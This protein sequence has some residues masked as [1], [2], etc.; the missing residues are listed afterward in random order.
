MKAELKR[1]VRKLPQPAQEISRRAYRRSQRIYRS[2]ATPYARTRISL[3]VKPL[4]FAWG[5]DRGQ[6]IARYYV[7]E[8]FLREFAKD[9]HGHCLELSSDRYTSRFG[10]KARIAKIDILNLEHGNPNTT[11]RADL[12]K[13]N[14]IPDN[15]FD[16]IIFTHALH[17]IYEFDK[18]IADLYRIL[19]PGGVL[20]V[21]VPHVSMCDPDERELWRFTQEGL[22]V[23][24]AHSFDDENI[25]MRAYGNSLT[26][27]GQ[28]RGL[29]AHEFT[30]RELHR[31]DLRFAVDI[32]ARAMKTY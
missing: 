11:I 9:I 4:S 13:P 1:V 22:R 27:A 29:A 28:I 3:G 20:L 19:R 17:V 6:E 16:C 26:A 14:D 5:G 25:T 18:A 2:P 31:H 32:C 30:K 15:T 23:A 7:E 21:A 12:T 10:E 8:L 24:L